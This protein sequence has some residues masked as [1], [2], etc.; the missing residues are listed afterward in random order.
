MNNITA[1]LIGAAVG[2][3]GGYFL[4]LTRTKKEVRDLKDQLNEIE[5]YYSE[6]MDLLEEKIKEIS[7]KMKKKETVTIDGEEI[8]LLDPEEWDELEEVD[9]EP[10][11]DEVVGLVTGKKPVTITQSKIHVIDDTEAME[12][13]NT[14]KA[15]LVDAWVFSCGTLTKEDKESPILDSSRLVGID[16]LER[17]KKVDSEAINPDGDTTFFPYFVYNENEQI[18]FEI[19]KEDRTYL[20]YMNTV[21]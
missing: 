7:D 14:H 20:E 15:K 12:L 13:V 19:S 2:L 1:G 3:G 17:I 18:V 6:Q 21:S 5:L 8:E 10:D 4:G 9:D 11:Y 16:I